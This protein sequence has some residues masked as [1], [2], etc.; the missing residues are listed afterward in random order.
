VRRVTAAVLVNDRMAMEGTGKLQHAV[1]K[2]RS[3]E[4][5]KRLEE[6]AQAAV[7]YDPKRGDSVVMQNISFTSNVPEPAPSVVQKTMEGAQSLLHTQPGLFKSAVTGLCALLLVMFVLRP[8]V[9]QI[10]ASGSTMQAVAELEA[11]VVEAE[12]AELPAAIANAGKRLP[13][14]RGHVFDYVAESVE[15]EPAQATRLLESWIG[16]AE[17]EA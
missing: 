13:S 2:P 4:E 10:T 17:T 5:L 9:K 8:A 14:G 1:W 6:L 16:T 11:P 7:G 12:P 15:R 3:G